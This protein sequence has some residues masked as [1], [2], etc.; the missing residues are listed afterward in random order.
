VNLADYARRLDAGMR[1]QLLAAPEMLEEA[2]GWLA[3]CARDQ[4]QAELVAEM[5][6]AEIVTLIGRN[7]DGGVGAFVADVGIPAPFGP[8]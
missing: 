4:E 2:R 7:Y 8:H 5:P 6:D 3:D 1:A